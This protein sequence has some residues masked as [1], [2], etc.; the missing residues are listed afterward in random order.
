MGG[1]GLDGADGA[2]LCDSF[3]EAR[4]VESQ[5]SI[6][7]DIDTRDWKEHGGDLRSQ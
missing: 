7:I 6:V 5:E 1:G 3:A 4:P 2:C